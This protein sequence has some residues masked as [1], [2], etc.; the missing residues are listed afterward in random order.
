MGKEAYTDAPVMISEAEMMERQKNYTIRVHDIAVACATFRKCL[1]QFR[2]LQEERTN[3]ER[4]NQ[5]L[6]CD[7]LP[8]V[9]SPIEIRT[10]LAKIRHFEEIE[11]NNSIDWTMG[12]DE[13]S[14]LTQNIYQKDLTRPVLQRTAVDDPGSYFESNLKKCM[15]VL[16]QVDILL[17]N[18]V[19]MERMYKSVQTDLMEVYRD[20]Q[21]EIESLFDRLTYRILRMQKAYMKS[22][23]EIVARWSHSCD[24][25][26]MDLWGL[27]NV[28]IMFQHL[29]VPLMMVDFKETAVKVQVPLSALWD[30]VTIRCVHTSFDHHSPQAKSYEPSTV[31]S[32][33]MPNAGLTDMEESV[34]GEWL[35]QTDIQEETL[36]NMNRRRE[37]YEELMQLIAERTE[38]AA[39][40]EKFG[41]GGDGDKRPKI[42]IPK[43][44]KT[45]PIVPP[46]MYPEIF[47]EFL[48]REEDQYKK[49]LKTYF[50]P[51]NLSLTSE[52]INLRE[53][54]I[55]GGVY[56]ISFVR[57]PDQTQFEKFNIVLHEKG[58]VLEIIP[59]VVAKNDARKSRVTEYTRMTLGNSQ[60]KLE[61]DELPFFVV[62]LQLPPDLCRWGKPEVCHF[63]KELQ[64]PTRT[65]DG[66]TLVTLNVLSPIR[67]STELSKREGSSVRSTLPNQ[68]S[69]P[70]KSLLK[71][72]IVYGN[73]PPRGEMITDFYLDKPL[74]AIEIIKL[75]K[76]C[77]PRIISSFKFPSEFIED[78]ITAE[79]LKAKP[80]RL[81]KRPET[82]TAVEAKTP[83]ES[84]FDYESQDRPERTYP[85]FN[86][87]GVIDFYSADFFPYIHSG[88]TATASGLVSTLETIKEKYL[89]RPQ[90]I[91]DQIDV[92]K[93]KKS[94]KRAEKSENKN[95]DGRSSAF[96]FRDRSSFA[97]VNGKRGGLEAKTK[98]NT[99][100]IMITISESD[101]NLKSTNLEIKTDMPRASKS[102]HWR[103]GS[104]MKRRS[105]RKSSRFDDTDRIRLLETEPPIWLDHWTKEYIM[106]SQIDLEKNTLT[107]RTDRLGIFGLAFKRYEHFPFRDWCLQPSE[108]NPDEIMLSLD[109]FHVRM[110]FYITARGVRGYVTD[111]VKGYTAKPVKYL[112]FVEPIS[113]FRE[114]R[115]LLIE[116]NLNIF[117]ENDAS[118]YI[119]NG[120][121][122]IKHIAT[123]LH[124]YN[125]MALQCKLM[126]FYRSSWNRLAQR[127][128]II[129]DM[130]IAKDNSDYSEV[131]MRIT[132][133]KTT[134]VKISEMCSDDVNVVK[135]RYEDT[136]RNVNN[137]NDFGQAIYSLN[138]HSLEGSNKD[139]MLFVYIKRLLNEIRPLS[140]S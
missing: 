67:I 52:E 124:T 31:N 111:L 135:L 44:P 14:I 119:K 139:A 95:V 127:R 65:P 35:M 117:A 87:A 128:D 60:M 38:Q 75:E 101:L 2:Q 105:T 92:Q 114:L 133:E 54:I 113:D 9:R 76:M 94:E 97:H 32:A 130:K 6:R 131:T 132:P 10:F 83:A 125:T 91:L 123:E 115:K 89:Q 85:I 69:P 20:V 47:N 107:F 102:R 59:Q 42:V 3:Q 11:A 116:K 15:D 23:N 27:Y 41:K 53:C 66:A 136:W 137:Y 30:C 138:P 100:D 110:F 96:S 106:D 55:V 81:V 90:E 58:R 21:L 26:R 99:S 140:Y 1:Q 17:D 29:E 64:T 86:K 36:S 108:D 88:N 71:Q 77:L 33:F 122:S 82:E 24:L 63:L 78:H 25:W 34:V 39:K 109:T 72:S 22:V 120:Y 126:K 28:P 43:V 98:I 48:F 104:M 13:R 93:S 18:E 51:D 70:L 40:E 103:S 4:W 50:H 118:Y 5:Y 129:M 49:F 19:E 121:F 84:Y 8:K 16:Q 62:T 73:F 74:N 12:V 61:D 56:N 80:N 112:D 68:F 7:G 79:A 134:F 57:R 45:V 46:G 37:E